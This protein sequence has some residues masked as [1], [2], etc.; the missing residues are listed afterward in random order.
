MHTSHLHLHPHR[1]TY[2][3]AYVQKPTP[4]YTCTKVAALHW[5]PSIQE[6]QDDSVAHTVVQILPTDVDL[7]DDSVGGLKG[8]WG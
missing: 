6:C 8:G 4:F 3:Y 1:H 5:Y 7:C 2:T